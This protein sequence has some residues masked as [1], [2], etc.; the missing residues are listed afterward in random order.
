MIFIAHSPYSIAGQRSLKCETKLK[1][2]AVDEREVH[3]NAIFLILP[4]VTCYCPSPPQD[5]VV[6]EPSC[7]TCGGHFFPPV[8]HMESNM[9]DETLENFPQ[10]SDTKVVD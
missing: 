4:R 5:V 2:R 3:W 10:A 1:R 8:I 6:K 7:L 9:G